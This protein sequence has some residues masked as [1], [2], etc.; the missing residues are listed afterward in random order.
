[1]GFSLVSLL[2]P[3]PS[4]HGSSTQ[5]KAERHGASWNKRCPDGR[6]VVPQYICLVTSESFRV[7]LSYRLNKGTQL[8]GTTG[9]WGNR[10]LEL[11]AL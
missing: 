1:M 4:E 6:R 8:T 5:G 10:Y 11:R 7:A 2:S 9:R 3:L